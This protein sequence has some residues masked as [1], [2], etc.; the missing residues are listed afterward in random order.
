MKANV[1]DMRWKLVATHLREIKTDALFSTKAC[2]ERAAALENVTATVPLEVD[3]DPSKRKATL[4]ATEKDNASYDGDHEPC[5]GEGVQPFTATT[6]HPERPTANAPPALAPIT[7]L[8]YEAQLVMAGNMAAGLNNSIPLKDV[9]EMT[10]DEMREELR[11]R[12]LVYRGVKEVLTQKVLA[13]RAGIKGLKPSPRMLTSIK[14][15]PLPNKRPHVDVPHYPHQAISVSP[16]AVH[17]PLHKRVKPT[18]FETNP[19]AD[20]STSNSHITLLS[21]APAYQNHAI[22]A[23]STPGLIGRLTIDDCAGFIYRYGDLST[24]D[25]YQEPVSSGRRLFLYGFHDT[26]TTDL[27]SDLLRKYS[28]KA[29]YPLGLP[30]HFAADCTDVVN[31]VEATEALNGKI[32]S[33]RIMIVRNAHEVAQSFHAAQTQ[34]A[35]MYTLPSQR[36][37]PAREF[38]DNATN[39]RLRVTN[40]PASMAAEDLMK[41]LANAQK[42]EPIGPG[43]FIVHFPSASSADVIRVAL[44]GLRI[45]GQA[46]DFEII[47]D[48]APDPMFLY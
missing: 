10:R 29:I 7:S 15:R 22:T 25:P 28:V 18:S 38:G 48:E 41:M 11:N 40:V 16:T 33:G 23:N 32:Y 43:S 37:T 47:E 12:G 44:Q 6:F 19:Y 21:S 9:H 5:F 36:I 45:C 42:C 30:G 27:I 2:Y 31:A 13:A 34:Q 35:S 4:A 8:S 39:C 3:A 24:L 20:A 26:M 46:I 1:E 17:D 14:P